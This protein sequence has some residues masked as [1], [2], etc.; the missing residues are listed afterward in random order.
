MTEALKNMEQLAF[1]AGRVFTPATPVSEEELFSGRME[2]IRRI[3]D[4]IN[5][6]GQ[7]AVVFGERGVGKTSLANI[8]ASKI[9]PRGQGKAL[10]PR[11]NCDS[12][13]DF[14][15]LWR[16]VF[17]QMDLIQKKITPGFQYTIYEETKTAADIIG[18]TVTPDEVRRLLT[19]MGESQLVVIVFDEFDR[20]TNPD[21]RR[22]IADTIKALSD[23]D[24]RATL[25][26]VGVAD[27]VDELI[28]E[29]Q[30]IERALV[31]I[32]MPRMSQP[33]LDEFLT[34][35]V[36]RLG[37]TITDS[38]RA[39][40]SL[41]SQGLPHYTHLLGL[42]S[43]RM[44][45]D[46]GELTVQSSHVKTAIS[47][48]VNDAQQS[49]RSDYRKAV[50]SPQKDNI[51]TQVLLACGLARTDEFGYFAAADVRDPLRAIMLGKP[52]E[53]PSFA[54]HLNDFCQ[55]H[56]GKVLKKTGAK[57]KFKYRF[58]NPLMQPLIIMKGLVDGRISE[59]TLTLVRE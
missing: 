34:K 33:E 44:A 50:T 53:I 21:A 11:I 5:Q 18:D 8:L 59:E 7:H 48:A 20:L 31:Q 46:A 54:K 56:R 41:L 1:E 38:A 10:T 16:K 51:Y 3:V 12:T 14:S 37:M 23:H 22:A 27:T 25:V 57:H 28:V 24:V 29:H 49:L 47:K 9:K 35:G 40:I 42:H 39:E 32:P 58:T 36:A 45:I 13:D 30:S 52:Y 26:V 2:Q 43:T 15:T 4:V 6:R 19:L 55:P 17:S